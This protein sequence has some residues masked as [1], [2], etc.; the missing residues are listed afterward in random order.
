MADI[1]MR[2]DESILPN[3]A[4][5]IMNRTGKTEPI[6]LTQFSTEIEGIGV[7]QEDIDEIAE[8]L[9]GDA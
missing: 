8:L 6:A 4:R 2:V 5:A 3:I 9:G 7:K 1:L